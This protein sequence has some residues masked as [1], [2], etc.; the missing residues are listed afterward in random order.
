MSG[1][2]PL[3]SSN[4]RFGYVAATVSP[5]DSMKAITA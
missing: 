4:V 2:D 1:T 3:T 5:F